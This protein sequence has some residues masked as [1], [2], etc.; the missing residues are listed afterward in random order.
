[1]GLTPGV[2]SQAPYL[3][4]LG[5]LAALA[6]V[7]QRPL[8]AP[9]VNAVLIGATA[10]SM[11]LGAW[12]NGVL[13][14]FILPGVISLYH[15]CASSG[16]AL[17][18]SLLLIAGM[19]LILTTRLPQ[20]H[21]AEMIRGLVK[22]LATVSFWQLSTRFW[23]AWVSRTRRIADDM[24]AAATRLES[25]LASAKESVELA[26]HTD[27]DTGLPNRQGFL[28]ALERHMKLVMASSSP[29]AGL[30]AAVRF[31]AWSEVSTHR[32][33]AVQLMLLDAL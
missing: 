25:E 4:F 13:P 16:R 15:L 27:P 28:R 31:R 8:A 1:M 7:W 26:L 21:E 23:H 6:L 3:G 30:V 14:L 20:G 29:V 11:L 19:A 9:W 24:H 10:F 17:G 5:F 18:I 33:P 12:N 22:T 32:K 2:N